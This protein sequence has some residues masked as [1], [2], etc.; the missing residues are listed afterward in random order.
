MKYLSILPLAALVF[1]L[2]TSCDRVTNPYPKKVSLAIDTTLYPGAWSDYVW[3]TFTPN[4]NTDANVL[5]EDFT[6]HTCNNCPPASTI[7]TGLHDANPTR[8]FVATIHTGPAG[9]GTLQ[10][11]TTEYPTDWTNPQGLQIGTFFGSQPGSGFQGNP[12][13]TV[14]RIL[15]NSQLTEAA[16]AWTSRVNTV[17][18]ANNLRVNLQS[19]CNYYD[20]T[21]GAFLHVEIDPIATYNPG[22]LKLVT[23]LIEDSI[24]GAQKMQDNTHNDAYVHRDVMRGCID[25]QAFGRVLTTDMINADNGN[26]YVTYSY[27]LPEAYN[28]QNMHFLVYVFDAATYEVLQVIDQR[29]EE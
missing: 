17:L 9:M 29:V 24:I 22:D 16:S 20:Q 5:L 28:P 15:R 8:V 10:E 19:V 13:G 2:Q 7:A 4:T 6:G 18:A 11:P 3:P 25:Q 23:Y 26:Y 21:R 1:F 27:K 14:N 12:R